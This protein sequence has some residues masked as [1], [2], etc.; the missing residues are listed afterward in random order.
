MTPFH[1]PNFFVVGAQRAGTTRL[2]HLLNQ[3]PDV[4]IPSKEPFFFHT[5]D[6][7]VERRDWYRSLYTDVTEPLIGDGSTYYSMADTYPGTA[8]RICA[9]NPDAKIIYAVRHPLRRIESAW[10]HLLS[11]GHLSSARSFKWA[12]MKSGAL[13]EPTLYYKQL[14]EY[15]AYF[16]SDQI[17]VIFFE[18]FARDEESHVRACLNFLGASPS[19]PVT[20]EMSHERNASE[21]MRQAWATLDLVRSTPGYGLIKKVIPQALKT[22]LSERLLQPIRRRAEWDDDTH[23]FVL[24]RLGDDPARLLESLGRPSTYWDLSDRGVR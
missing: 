19:A 13:L 21:G 20:D 22:S 15:R 1:G 23:A 18:E 5:V 6:A 24:E 4:S 2:C 14:S 11:V 12:V 8:A 3:H 17:H 16:S 10:Y 9:Y 7:M